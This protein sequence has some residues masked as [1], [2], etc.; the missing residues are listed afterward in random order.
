MGHADGA[1]LALMA[2]AAAS[3]LSKDES[4]HVVIEVHASSPVQRSPAEAEV[5]AQQQGPQ[6]TTGPLPT[7]LDHQ[8]PSAESLQRYN[9]PPLHSA[10]PCVYCSLLCLFAADGRQACASWVYGLSRLL[11]N[12]DLQ[13]MYLTSTRVGAEG[14][15][16]GH[17]WWVCKFWWGVACWEWQLGKRAVVVV[18]S[19][20]NGDLRL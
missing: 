17:K 4:P 3:R 20:S 9:P 16:S 5:G 2:A 7:V 8:Q 14:W 15:C 11:W 1:L 6:Q 19:L 18:C 12:K 13:C 10:L